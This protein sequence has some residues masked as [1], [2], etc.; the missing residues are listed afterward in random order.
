MADGDVP[1]VSRWRSLLQITFASAGRRRN[2][3]TTETKPRTRAE[4]F[5]VERR[6]FYIQVLLLK[7]YNRNFRKSLA[8]LASKIY[9]I[10][11]HY[12]RSTLAHTQAL[13]PRHLSNTKSAGTYFPFILALYYISK[14]LLMHLFQV[15]LTG[16]SFFVTRGRVLLA[17][18]VSQGLY[19]SFQYSLS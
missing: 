7:T 17:L 11:F 13:F 10:L 5:A 8:C 2:P 18:P 15:V 16:A 1:D 6:K 12:S 14:N 19:M 9:C 3:P 4:K